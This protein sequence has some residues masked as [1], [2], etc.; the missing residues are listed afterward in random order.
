[1]NISFFLKDN[2]GNYSSKRLLAVAWGFGILFTWEYVSITTKTMAP[3]SWEHI[4]IVLSLAGVVAAGK[5]GEGK[6]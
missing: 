4:G 6:P 2:A 5:W 1:M 3:L